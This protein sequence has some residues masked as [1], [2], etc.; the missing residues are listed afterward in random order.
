MKIYAIQQQNRWR[1][2]GAGYMRDKVM[3]EHFLDDSKAYKYMHEKYKTKSSPD[4]S[5]IYS[6]IEIDVIE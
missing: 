2:Q 4:E 5:E 1:E 3:L 6:I